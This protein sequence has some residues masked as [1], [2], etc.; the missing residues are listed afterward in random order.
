VGVLLDIKKGPASGQRLS[1]S[2]GQS[3]VIGRA[4]DRAQFAVPQDN[5]M[6]GVHFAVECG[7]NG[8]RV[9]DKKST[10]G[11][12]L[13]GSKVQEAMLA[14][15]DEICAGQT[16]LAVRIVPDAELAAT[17][18]NTRP[19]APPLRGERP[20]MFAPAQQVVSKEAPAARV[21]A[22]PRQ[23][24]PAPPDRTYKE[25]E[26][27]AAMA[28]P[29]VAHVQSPAAPPPATSKPQQPPATP[30]RSG[31]AP[32]L[33]IGKWAFSRIPDGWQ[34]QEGLGIQLQTKDDKVFPSNIGAMEEPVGPGITLSKYVE[35]QTKMLREYLRD[36]KIDAALPPK[37]PG[38]L[39]TVAI[40]V[41]YNTKDGHAI[42]Y[43]RLYARSGP[44]IGVLTLTALEKDLSAVRQ[45]YDSFLGGASFIS[46]N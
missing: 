7:A 17:S 40:E 21:S 35:A 36:P 32:V 37:L 26:L 4:S 33:V 18:E 12:F 5:H 19:P 29:P 31:A 25:A 41:R 30:V 16:V 1:L 43:H 34:I 20:E 15:G 42:Y 13:N 11:T 3:I 28:P 14:T 23:A 9:V 39:E 46:Q 10:N 2:S 22:V 27:S 24:N 8:C 44:T 45:A 38:A 6:S